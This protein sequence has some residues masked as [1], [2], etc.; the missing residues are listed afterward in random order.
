VFISLEVTMIAIIQ[1]QQ[2]LLQTVKVFHPALAKNTTRA[3]LGD[4]KEHNS[5]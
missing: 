5:L 3:I 1:A 2:A 4:E